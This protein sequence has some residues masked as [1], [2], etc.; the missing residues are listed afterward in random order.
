MVDWNIYKALEVKVD[1][2]INLGRKVF[3]KEEIIRYAKENDPLPF[4]LDESIAKRSFFGKL[5]CSGG[6]AFYYFYVNRWMPEYGPTVVGG[7][8][9]SEW[10]FFQPVGVDEE[11]HGKATVKSIRDSKSNSRLI[12]VVW[13]FEFH[14]KSGTLV[15]SLNLKVLHKRK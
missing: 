11:I 4:H 7:L 15:Q 14:D 1:K 2:N 12:I 10:N 13:L 5:V 8:G 9:V 3:S 6:Q